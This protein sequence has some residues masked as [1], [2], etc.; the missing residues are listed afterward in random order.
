MSADMAPPSEETYR[1]TLEGRTPDGD[2]ATLIVTRQGLGQ[3]GRVW[4]TFLGAI[5]TTHVM[6]DEQADELVEMIRAARRPQS[7][8]GRP[9]R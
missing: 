4:V 1:A 9:H 5:K 3:A 7:A 2:P 6:T 8:R